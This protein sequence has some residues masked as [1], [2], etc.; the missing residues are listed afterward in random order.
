MRVPREEVR[1]VEREAAQAA[2]PRQAPAERV[3]ALQSTAGNRAVAALLARAP[4]TAEPADSKG[5]PPKQPAA[6]S[7][8]HIV[9]G[10]NAPIPLESFSAPSPS[11][12]GVLPDIQLHS[13]VGPH[14]P[15]L[16]RAAKDGGQFDGEIVMPDGRKLVFKAALI[17]SY[18][19]S[20][21]DDNKALTED[22]S[23]NV[24]S[25]EFV[26]PPK[27][28]KEPPRRESDEWDLSSVRG[29]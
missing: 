29:G 10:K 27:E 9:L 28:G 5:P 8:S 6:P 14:S 20:Q 16:A 15:E 4:D 23:I 1:D 17:T 2:P 22:W 25:L 7:G 11:K 24:Q 21:A 13:L 12:K 18:S 19:T 26:Q 3:L